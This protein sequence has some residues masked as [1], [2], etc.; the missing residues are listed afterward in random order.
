M[1]PRTHTLPPGGVFFLV[2]TS[3]SVGP[4]LASPV[5]SSARRLL[6][7]RIATPG[8]NSAR[9]PCRIR[10]AH[11]RSDSCRQWQARDEARR[12]T[13]PISTTTT[14]ISNLTSQILQ[15]SN[16]TNDYNCEETATTACSQ[17]CCSSQPPA[18]SWHRGQ[19]QQQPTELSNTD[20]R[21]TPTRSTSIPMTTLCPISTRPT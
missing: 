5:H 2:W 6:L 16:L 14:P 11:F 3:A 17:Q 7:L 8:T 18:P 1:D 15:I 12:P 9:N 20:R 21:S 13:R 19:P 10:R 4:D